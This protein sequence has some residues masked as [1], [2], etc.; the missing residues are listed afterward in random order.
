M[1]QPTADCNKCQYALLH[2][3]SNV[4]YCGHSSLRDYTRGPY[5]PLPYPALLYNDITWQ[6][7]CPIFIDAAAVLTVHVDGE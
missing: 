3:P 1:Q 6:G 5:E 4:L 2:R 7:N